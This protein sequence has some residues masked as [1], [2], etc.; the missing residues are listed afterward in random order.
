MVNK[1]YVDKRFGE[2]KEA[3]ENMNAKA[4]ETRGGWFGLTHVS[5]LKHYNR[6]KDKLRPKSPFLI[7]ERDYDTA[8]AVRLE[9]SKIN[10]PRIYVLEGDLFDKMFNV[11]P[12]TGSNCVHGETIYRVPLFSYGHLDFCCTAATL[13]E[14]HFEANIR[15]LAKWWALKDTFYLDVSVAHRGDKG[16]KSAKIMLEDYVPNVFLQL[17]WKMHYGRKID[18]RDTSMMRN[19]FYKFERIVPWN[20]VG[21]NCYADND[22]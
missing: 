2:R 13:S 14:Q 11:Y 18:Y 19:V 17:N 8:R 9:A 7:A 15:K 20:K 5:V 21:R 10:D 4:M 3:V 6:F 12:S 22:I 16:M 1:T